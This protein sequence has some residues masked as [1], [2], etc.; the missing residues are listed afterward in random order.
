MSKIN[1][2]MLEALKECLVLIDDL[3]PGVKYIALQNYRRMNDAPYNAEKI[4]RKA[5]AELK[6]RKGKNHGNTKTKC[7]SGNQ[8]DHQ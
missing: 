3:M 1:T 4:I 2:E 6:K 7:P 5:E 8:S